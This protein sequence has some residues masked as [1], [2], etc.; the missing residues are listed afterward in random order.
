MSSIIEMLNKASAR[1]EKGVTAEHE[2][3]KSA[4]QLANTIYTSMAEEDWLELVAKYNKPMTWAERASKVKR[5]MPPSWSAYWAEH[6]MKEPAREAIV[7]ERSRRF[8]VPQEVIVTAFGT[9]TLEQVEAY[10]EKRNADEATERMWRR[11]EAHWDA[12][13][14]S[15]HFCSKYGTASAELWAEKRGY[16]NEEDKHSERLMDDAEEARFWQERWDKNMDE[17][18][19]PF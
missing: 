7:K 8:G 5:A 9:W 18:C 12:V 3:I 13:K 4:V 6:K 14:P 2:A 15:A 10:E 11:A 17:L 19:E 16:Y 1:Y